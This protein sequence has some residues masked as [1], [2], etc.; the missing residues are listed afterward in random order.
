MFAIETILEG[1]ADSDILVL[2]D[3]SYDMLFPREKEV[4][5]YFSQGMTV[6]DITYKLNRSPK[7]VSI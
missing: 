5:R 1:P 3:G 2:P 7:I 4:L 6:I